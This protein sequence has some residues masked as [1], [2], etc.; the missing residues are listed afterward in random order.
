M[1]QLIAWLVARPQNAVIGLAATLLPVLLLPLLQSASGIIPLLQIA[2][3]SIMV[4]LVLR[5]GPRLAIME[6]AIAAA[7]L[8]IVAFVAE[9]PT[10]HVVGAVAGIWVPAVL[11]G[12]VLQAT[13]SLTLTVQVSALLAAA[14][15]V[16][17]FVAVDDL[18]AQWQP[19]L[20]ALL[21]WS[22]ERGLA[23]QA[24]LMEAQPEMTASMLTMAS[25]LAY[26][27]MYV[28]FLALGYW[29]L[30]SLPGETQ[31]YGRFCDLN[32]GRVIALI[33]AVLSLA[34]FAS[35]AVWIQGTAFVL[36]AVFWL[37]GLAV[38]HWMHADGHLPLFVVFATYVLMPVLHVFLVMALAVLGYTDAWFGYRRRAVVKN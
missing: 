9:A 34:A 12:V 26:W 37:Q 30:R 28:V 23:E 22:R 10:P 33:T 19:T 27:M 29:L 11:A 31:D 14:A 24:E 8:A 16:I 15:T 7:L 13:R 17:Y 4:L 1:Q 25:V 35:D 36:F 6:G 38:L 20:D 21:E 3:G 18:V 5:Q 32:F 2:S